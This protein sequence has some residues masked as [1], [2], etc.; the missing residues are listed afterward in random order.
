ME[1]ATRVE[2]DKVFYTFIMVPLTVRQ[3]SKNNKNF[4]SLV[5]RS[6]QGEEHEVWVDAKYVGEIVGMLKDQAIYETEYAEIFASKV[7]EV[8]PE[9]TVC[10]ESEQVLLDA[11]YIYVTAS[12]YSKMR[13]KY[14]RKVI[15]KLVKHLGKATIVVYKCREAS[16]DRVEKY[17][18]GLIIIIY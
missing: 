13:Y 15:K 11:D 12:D 14:G 3:G 2:G 16:S 1:V 17:T 18:N 6:L 7:T 5:N 9:V 4:R 10:C 8:R